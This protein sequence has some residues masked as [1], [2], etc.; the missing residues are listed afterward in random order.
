MKDRDSSNKKLDLEKDQKIYLRSKNS[1]KVASIT[2][3]YDPV[4]IDYSNV[5]LLK[6]ELE[7]T[8]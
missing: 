6:F 3:D 7:P 4:V 8:D 5:K 2:G 1:F